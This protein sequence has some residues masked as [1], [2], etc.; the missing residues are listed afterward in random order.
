MGWI[1]GALIAI[2]ALVVA[3]AIWSEGAG[4]ADPPRRPARG[5]R[6]PRKRCP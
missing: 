1:I 3:Y 5:R 2:V 4:A 6:G